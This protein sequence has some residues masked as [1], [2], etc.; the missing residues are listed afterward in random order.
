M[1][2]I[3]ALGRASKAGAL[4]TDK[5]I[6]ALSFVIRACVDMVEL[7]FLMVRYFLKG[8]L[9]VEG[10]MVVFWFMTTDPRTM[11]FV[12]FLGALQSPVLSGAAIWGGLGLVLFQAIK[13]CSR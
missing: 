6:K 11:S 3:E 10:L 9:A 5:L 12:D 8:A 13:T 1:Q 4:A 7:C 2:L